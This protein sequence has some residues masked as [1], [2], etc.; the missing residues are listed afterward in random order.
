MEYLKELEVKFSRIIQSLK[1]ELSSFRTN[2][3]S[4][5]LV[6][7]IKVD[8][9]GQL[10][11][12]KQMGSIAL[13]PPRDLVISVWDK[14]ALPAVAK[15]IESENLGLGVSP[16]GN[17]IRVRT[18][19]LTEERRREIEKLVRA[20]VEETRIKMRMERDAVNKSIN[21]EID[22]DLK[23]RAKEDLQKL[24]DKFNDA[25]E[26]ALKDKL[27]DIAS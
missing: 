20:S 8:Y 17:T 25:I 24:V 1:E 3:P 13:E 7:G 15:A 19:E 27:R 21:S 23:F 14:N 4:P 16:Q 22:K 12:I 11:T 26:N 2:R 10:L 6:E 18:P 5:K 9:L